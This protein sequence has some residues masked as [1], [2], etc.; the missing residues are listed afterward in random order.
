VS[1][2]RA[3]SLAPRVPLSP[4]QVLGDSIERSVDKFCDLA[5]IDA[6]DESAVAGV[7]AR[8]LVHALWAMADIG[9]ARNDLVAIA[10]GAAN[11]AAN[12]IEAD[13]ASNS[14]GGSA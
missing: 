4:N 7:Y 14:P 9:I 2:L 13:D 3:A 8:V 5:H 6:D 10:M 1:G 11:D 12:R